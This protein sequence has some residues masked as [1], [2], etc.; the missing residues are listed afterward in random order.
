M[1]SVRLYELYIHYRVGVKI[2]RVVI[3]KCHCFDWQ[4]YVICLGVVNE[5]LVSC[6]VSQKLF[7]IIASNVY[8]VFCFLSKWP[9]QLKLT[10]LWFR[11]CTA[12]FWD[13]SLAQWISSCAR[14]AFARICAVN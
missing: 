12:I 14:A 8:G 2:L 10:S 3:D 7:W 13:Q 9:S 1:A 11:A 4:A 5:C 6:D